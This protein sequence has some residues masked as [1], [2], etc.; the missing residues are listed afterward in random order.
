MYMY[1]KDNF[2]SEKFQVN[3]EIECSHPFSSILSYIVLWGL[4]VKTSKNNKRKHSR[5]CEVK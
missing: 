2:S 1:S 3:V 5:K 4:K